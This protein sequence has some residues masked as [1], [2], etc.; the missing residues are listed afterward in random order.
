MSDLISEKIKTAFNML[1]EEHNPQLFLAIT[2][3]KDNAVNYASYGINDDEAIA[4]LEHMITYFK[5]NGEDDQYIDQEN[6]TVH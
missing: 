4:I 2:I 1:C 6:R 5:D 3:D